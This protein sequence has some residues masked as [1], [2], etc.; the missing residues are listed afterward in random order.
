VEFPGWYGIPE[1]SF[2]SER[3][4]AVKH[5][6]PAAGFDLAVQLHGDGSVM[7]DFVSILPSYTTAAF[8]SHL[9]A[10]LPNPLDGGCLVPYPEEL[11]E[12][13]RLLKL[14]AALGMPA[15]GEHLEFPVHE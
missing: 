5:A 12:P 14:P 13:R 7:N 3:F 4:Q 15:T 2:D 6:L 10:G 11:P 8:V 1:R 9:D